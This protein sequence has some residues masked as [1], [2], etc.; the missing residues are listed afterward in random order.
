MAWAKPRGFGECW[1][2]FARRYEREMLMQTDK[3]APKEEPLRLDFGAEPP[4]AA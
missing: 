4:A 1:P 2:E 3:S